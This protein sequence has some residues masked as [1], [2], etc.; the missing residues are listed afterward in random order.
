MVI[1]K[2]AFMVMSITIVVTL[3]MDFIT[4]EIVRKNHLVAISVAAYYPV[5]NNYV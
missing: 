1:I 2:A 5:E 3:I 4:Q